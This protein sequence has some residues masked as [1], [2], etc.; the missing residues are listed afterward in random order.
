LILERVLLF[1]Y[2]ATDP[3]CN[4]QEKSDTKMVRVAF[5]LRFS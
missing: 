4:N 5:R 2:S 3:F 1:A